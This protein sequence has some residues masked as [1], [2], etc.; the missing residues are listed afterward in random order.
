MRT[1]E[2][3]LADMSALMEASANRSMTD[4]EVTQYEAHEAELVK[5]QRDNAIRNRHAAYNAPVDAVAL[6]TGP[7]PTDKGDSLD[8]AFAAY[9]RTG[10]PNADISGL[11]VQNAQTTGTGSSGGFLVPEGFRAQI[12][13][14]IKSFGG[15]LNNCEQIN[16]ETGNPLPIPK[17]NDTAN[18][19]VIASENTAPAS[20]ADLVFSEVSLGAY[21]FAA[22]GTGGSSL[23]VPRALL[24]DAAFDVAGYVARKLGQRI[25]RKMAAVAVSGSGSGEPQGVVAG[26]TGLEVVTTTLTYADLVALVTSLDVAHWQT[27]KWYMN[28][29]SFGKVAQ[30]EDTNGNLIF[31]QIEMLTPD[32]GTRIYTTITVGAVTAP[33]ILDNGFSDLSL[34]AGEGVNWAAFGDLVEGY[35]WRSVRDIE[36]LVDPYSAGN[37]RQV[38]YDAWARADGAQKDTTAYK[39]M[40]GHTT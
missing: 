30:L 29:V 32:G 3:I 10:Q 5:A 37:K 40:A 6:R 39:V 9:L 33:V 27:A 7:A 8:K 31:K 38:L 20:G 25:A 24:Q 15:V 23:A 36:I 4:D 14:V 16:T 22:S 1:V 11:Q 34:S 21:E 19:G 13:D 12:I 26:I 17:N 18:S 35:I 28:Q 2:D